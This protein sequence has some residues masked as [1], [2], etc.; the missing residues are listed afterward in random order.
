MEAGADLGARNPG[1]HAIASLR[2]EKGYRAWGRELTPDYN[3][4]EAGLSFAVKLDKGDFIGRDALL[5]AKAEPPARRLLN[6]VALAPDSP[7]AHGGE[8]ILRNREPA[9]EI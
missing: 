6:F 5:A 9:A 2:L 4:Y 8:L 1:Y 3:P 7:I